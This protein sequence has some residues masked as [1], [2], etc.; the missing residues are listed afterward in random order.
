[1]KTRPNRSEFHRS[2]AHALKVYIVHNGSYIIEI[3]LSVRNYIKQVI[4]GR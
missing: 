4:Y 2:C 3:R 1:M